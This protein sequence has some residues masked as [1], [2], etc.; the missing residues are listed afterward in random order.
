MYDPSIVWSGTYTQFFD[1]AGILV[2][3]EFF[4]S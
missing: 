1:M 3:A 4:K 2:Q